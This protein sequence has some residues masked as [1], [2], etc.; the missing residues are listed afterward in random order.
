MKS[1]VLAY[2]APVPLVGFSDVLLMPSYRL[3]GGDISDDV[4]PEVAANRFLADVGIAASLPDIRIMGVI[5][6]TNELVHVCHCPVRVAGPN[7]L[8][9][10]GGAFWSPLN[11]VMKRGS[12]VPH[13]IRLA[14][15]LCRSGMANWAFTNNEGIVGLNLEGWQ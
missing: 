9:V 10:N 13:S 15:A 5:Q 8:A 3:P 7:E 11:E 1:F 14:V 6:H 12:P 4:M 2:A